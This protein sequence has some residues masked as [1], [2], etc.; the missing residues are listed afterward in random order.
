MAVVAQQ[1]LA[2]QMTSDPI[3]IVGDRKRPKE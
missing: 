3:V 1:T 2:D